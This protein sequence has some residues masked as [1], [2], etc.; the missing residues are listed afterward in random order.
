MHTNFEVTVVNRTDI[1][2]SLPSDLVVITAD[3]TE[4][5]TYDGALI[6]AADTEGKISKVD[7]TENF[8]LGSDGLINKNISTTTLFDAQANSCLLYTSPS[9]RD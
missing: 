5:A 4:K 8:T 2:N 1:V 9:P 3:G 7:L 6:Y